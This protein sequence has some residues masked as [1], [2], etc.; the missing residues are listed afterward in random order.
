MTV[1]LQQGLTRDVPKRITAKGQRL[2]CV[3]TGQSGSYRNVPWSTVVTVSS[4]PSP[5]SRN[6]QRSSSGARHGPKVGVREESA[7]ELNPLESDK[8]A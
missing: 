5:V 4:S 3:L 1:V 6:S 7:G 2:F 8:V